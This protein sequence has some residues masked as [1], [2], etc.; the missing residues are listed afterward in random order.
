MTTPT[1][2]PTESSAARPKR[3]LDPKV[4]LAFKRVFGEHADL[5]KS[6]LNALLP[7]PDDGQIESLEYLTP[8]QVPEI[9]GMF[10][11]S[12][13]DVKCVDQKGRIFIVE[14]QMLWTASFEQRMVFGASQ[15]Y[16]KQ[17]RAGQKYSELRPVY[18]LAIINETL[19]P[20]QLQKVSGADGAVKVEG[21]T[22]GAGD[23][24]YHHYKIVNVEYP[25]Q[26][27]KGL[28]FVIIELPKFRAE[29]R[30]QKRLQT[31]WLRFLREVGQEPE[32]VIDEA[33]RQDKDVAQAV[34]LM[35]Q[36]GFTVAELDG[37]HIALD[38][39]RIEISALGDAKAEGKAEGEHAKAQ[40]IAAALLADGMSV[41]RVAALTG[42]PVEQMGK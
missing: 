11:H 5:L 13:V 15:A 12:I 36:S 42:L 4:D 18:A 6:F 24:Y 33:L 9:P 32:Q 34:E 14:M 41:E 1:A 40:A 22:G 23:E 39:A 19:F 16:V 2:A 3:Y 37:Y 21:A 17:L 27:L 25:Q 29:N 26:T 35:E 20:G 30:K 8:E 10:K 7:L 31:L 38:R 28:E